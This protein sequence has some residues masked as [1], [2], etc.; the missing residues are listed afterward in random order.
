MGLF[1]LRIISGY[2]K[3]SVVWLVA[4]KKD[5]TKCSKY[6]NNNTLII[7]VSIV[8]IIG[9]PI[10]PINEHENLPTDNERGICMSSKKYNQSGS[11][12][13]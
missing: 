8:D 6:I 10:W 3:L 11:A 13:R 12:S 5:W 1:Q 4:R 9:G 7:L 2:L